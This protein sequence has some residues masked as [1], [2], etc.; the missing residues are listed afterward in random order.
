VTHPLFVLGLNLGLGF[1]AL[2]LRSFRYSSSD[3]FRIF[4]RMRRRSTTLPQALRH[5]VA[6]KGPGSFRFASFVAQP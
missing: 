5:V 1:E 3:A 4:F 2:C 6:A